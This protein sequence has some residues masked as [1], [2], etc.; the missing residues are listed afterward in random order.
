MWILKPVSFQTGF[1]YRLFIAWYVGL[2]CFVSETENVVC[3]QVTEKILL[4]DSPGEWAHR[5]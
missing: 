4:L 1:M 2:V 5:A 3:F